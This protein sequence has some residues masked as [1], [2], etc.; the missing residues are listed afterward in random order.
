MST[1]KY[2]V[3]I[4]SKI[5]FLLLAVL[6][7]LIVLGAL[8]FSWVDKTNG[9]LLS[10][11][12][13]RK[14]FLF[15]PESYNPS[16]PTPLVI[17]IHGYA[18]WP[19]HQMVL[20]GWN[21]LAEENGF[22]V[23]YPSGTSFPRRWVTSRA[24]GNPEQGLVDVQFISD[25]IDQLSIEYNIDLTRIYANGL[26]NGGG[27]SALL[28]C[29]LSERIAAVGS[30]SGAYLFSPDDCDRS[31]PMPMIAF[32]GTS[33]PIVPYQGGPSSSFDLPFPLIPEWIQGWA[34][35]NGCALTPRELPEQGEVSGIRYTD[36]EQDAEVI[37]Y[38]IMGGGHSWPGGQPL[39]EWIVGHTTQDIDATRVMWEFFQGYSLDH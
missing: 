21:R 24:F 30:V 23:V 2:A 7:V 27:M 14:Y 19:A 3:K 31:R 35:R 28:G 5:F 18:E 38:T 39:P 6:L 16:N 22:L 20:S 37:F 34:E 17:S 33:D 12:Q 36:C 9:S 15:V 26:S 8:L 32:H 25:L 1:L 10:S 13:E 11:G 29:A 4:L